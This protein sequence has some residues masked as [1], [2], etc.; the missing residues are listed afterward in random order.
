MIKDAHKYRF[1]Q[2]FLK[3]HDLEKQLT[4][5]QNAYRKKLQ[6]TLDALKKYMPTCVQWTKPFGGLFVWITL[7]VGMDATVVLKK[8]LAYKIGFMPGQAFYPHHKVK[9]SLRLNFSYPP[10]KD[11]EEGVKRLAEV[12]NTCKTM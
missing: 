3:Q 11:I 4:K 1:D 12:I 10:E 9:N 5:I 6:I 8:A 2:E 7:P